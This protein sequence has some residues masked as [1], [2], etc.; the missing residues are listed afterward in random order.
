KQRSRTD[1]PVTKEVKRWTDQ[2]EARLQD[3]LSNVDWEM[4][5]TNSADINE[6]TEVSLSYINMLTDSIIPTVKIRSFP[7]QKPWVDREVR[8]A[9]KTRAMTYNAGLISGDMTDY[10]AASY[11][12]RRAIKDAK[13]RYRDRVEAD[14]LEGDPVRVWKGLRT[15]TG[16]ERKSPPMMNSQQVYRGCHLKPHAH[17]LNSPGGG[18]W[19]LCEDAVH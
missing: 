2:S 6:F 14:F 18:E 17:H 16:F 3:A 15:I 4:F 13:R 9:L 1:P 12:L 19:E 11:S 7:N 8:T 10:K 5:K